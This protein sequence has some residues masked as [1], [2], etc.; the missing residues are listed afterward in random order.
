MLRKEIISTLIT[1][2]VPASNNKKYEQVVYDSD[3]SV[4][5]VAIITQS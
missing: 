3:C 5:T 2:L 1:A 4:V